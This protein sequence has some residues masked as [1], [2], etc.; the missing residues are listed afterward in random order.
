MDRIKQSIDESSWAVVRR[1]KV[2]NYVFIDGM[3]EVSK[4]R[5]ELLYIQVLRNILFY[6]NA[7]GS[8]NAC[9]FDDCEVDFLLPDGKVSRCNMGYFIPEAQELLDELE[10]K[11]FTTKE[12]GA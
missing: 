6:L 10:E 3:R 4:I 8:P 11:V 9:E 1:G 12:G 5:K 2:L 7:G